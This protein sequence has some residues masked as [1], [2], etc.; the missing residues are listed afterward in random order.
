MVDQESDAGP[1]AALLRTRWVPLA[2]VR[3]R[4]TA[5]L[6]FGLPPPSMDSTYL[7]ALLRTEAPAGMRSPERRA[8]LGPLF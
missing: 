8:V 4:H 5:A 2:N 3:F 6:L 1:L 7:G